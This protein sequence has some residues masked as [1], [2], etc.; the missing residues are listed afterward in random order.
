MSLCERLDEALVAAFASL[1]PYGC[2]REAHDEN[3]KP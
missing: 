1:E 3:R 2:V